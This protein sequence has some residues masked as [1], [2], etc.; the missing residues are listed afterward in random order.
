M[1]IL[2][3]NDISQNLKRILVRVDYNV[4][5]DHGHILDDSRIRKTIPT[6]KS[7]LSKGHEIILLTH[8]GR[9]KGVEPSLS[10]KPFCTV[11]ESLLGQPVGFMDSPSAVAPETAIT[12]LENLRFNKGEESN[13]PTFSKSLADL[14]NA[15]VNDA[16]SVSH[17]AH[18]SVQGITKYLPS[19]GGLLFISEIDALDKAFSNPKRP[20]MAIVGGGKISSKID[21]LMNLVRTADCVVV[22]GG[23]ANTFLRAHGY[24]TGKSLVEEDKIPIALEI[25]TAA[26][27][28]GCTLFIPEDV[29]GSKTLEGTPKSYA[30]SHIPEDYR[31][32]DFGPKAQGRLKEMI[33]N[34]KTIIWNGPLG[35]FEHR[36]YDQAS[37]TIAHEIGTLTNAGSLTSIAGGGE[38]LALLQES[39]ELENFTYTSTAGGAFLEYCEGKSLPGLVTLGV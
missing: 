28:Q 17:R 37:L 20:L 8:L 19:F 39:G 16:F 2:T 18:A 7:L 12:L 21:L 23:I 22:G 10:V 9:P 27:A 30:I 38:T 3:I 32:L 4:P 6:L 5:M 14:G 31:I 36:P 1:S 25:I 15:Y 29:N 13:D 26:H 33:R 24:A 35:F 11:L 34:Y